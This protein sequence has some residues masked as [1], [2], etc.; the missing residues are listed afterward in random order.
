MF[1]PPLRIWGGL[2]MVASFAVVAVQ[3][4]LGAL[5]GLMIVGGLLFSPPGSFVDV[6]LSALVPDFLLGELASVAIPAHLNLLT[7]ICLWTYLILLPVAHAGLF[8]NFYARRSFPKNEL[9][10]K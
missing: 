8:Y 6:G 3:I 7:A 4:K 5:C 9:R 2:L 1:I 10:R